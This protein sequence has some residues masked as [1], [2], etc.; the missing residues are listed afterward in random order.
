MHTRR[1]FLQ[2]SAGAASL[3]AL[4]QSALAASPPPAVPP[5]DDKADGYS[6]Q[7]RAA[8][9]A[10][11]VTGAS[12]A[13]WD[14]RTTHTAVA[15]LRNS[16]T[17]DPVT[18]DT[19]MHV[20]SITK[21]TTTALMM[22]LVDERKIALHD[23]VSRHLGDLRLRDMQALR[24]IT[25]QM[26]VNHTSGINGEWLPEYGPD[27][28]RIVDT[29]NRCADLDQLFAP[30]EQTSYCNTALVIAGYLTQRLRA[31]SWYTLVKTNIYEPLGMQHALVDPLEVPRFRASIGD[32]SDAVTGKMVQT[33]RP[34]L[35][36][37]FAPAGATQMTSATDLV[38]FARALINGGVGTNG[39]RILSQE[40]A[41]CMTEPTAQFVP[42]D[43]EVTKVGLGWMILPGGVLNH[44]GGGP[45]VR[46]E[47]YAHPA[48][49][50]ALAL[51]TNCDKGAT[52]AS[53]FLTPI[54]ESW[55]GLRNSTR[56]RSTISVDVK[57][58][59]GTYENNADRYTV[60]AVGDGLAV[61]WHDKLNTYDNTSQ[62]GPATMLY[63]IGNDTFKERT[64]AS[65]DPTMAVRF[66]R[67]SDGGRIRF[68][69]SDDR[70]LARVH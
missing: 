48:S 8:L 51:L 23:P 26:L 21:I 65:Q 22:Q 42:I 49:G 11:G 67:S 36:P 63:A 58:Y 34:F 30:G 27:Q 20:G 35:A 41:Q 62:D 33:T 38:V 19:V 40:S 18:V 17:Q 10:T 5:A 61:R 29:I 55:T 57:P 13:Y 24:R 28:E 52:L 39:T 31:K 9:V 44:G 45:G 59:V 25:C 15:G 4:P 37:S 68:M 14:G 32:L 46:S 1:A 6:R 7:L 12:F 70:L 47:V 64:G 66:V 69:A 60:A 43:S 16:V 54:L 50:R 56:A 53:R 3:G 2:Y